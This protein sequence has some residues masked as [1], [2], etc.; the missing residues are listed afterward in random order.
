[1]IWQN[2]LHLQIQWIDRLGSPLPVRVAR[3]SFLWQ[4][5]A[6]YA[7]DATIVSRWIKVRGVSV[8]GGELDVWSG[9]PF[10]FDNRNL[11]PYRTEP[12]QNLAA[13][14][15]SDVT[16][17]WVRFELERWNQRHP[18][19]RLQRAELVAFERRILAPQQTTSIEWRVLA[20]ADTGRFGP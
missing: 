6:L 16:S 8:D 5:W 1:V 3:T 11:S 19:S 4:N 2:L 18:E 12:W 14:S 7:P 20:V 15:D 10:T 9:R 13:R 17:R